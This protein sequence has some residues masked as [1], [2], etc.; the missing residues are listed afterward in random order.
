MD[1]VPDQISQESDKQTMQGL[2]VLKEINRI[3]RS[4]LREITT[5]TDTQLKPYIQGWLQDL[6]EQNEMLVSVVAE[7]E[8]EAAMRVSMLEEKMR[9]STL[10][11]DNIMQKYKDNVPINFVREMCQ[12][13]MFLQNDVYNLLEFIKRIR[14]CNNWSTVGLK[15]CTVDPNVLQPSELDKIHAV[16]AELTTKL[17]QTADQTQYIQNESLMQD[18]NFQLS[19]KEEEINSVKKSMLKA[20]DSLLVKVSEKYEQNLALRKTVRTLE[21]ELREMSEEIQNRDSLIAELQVQRTENVED[22]KQLENA[23]LQL[24][25]KDGIIKQLHDELTKKELDYKRKCEEMQKSMTTLQKECDLAKLEWQ[26]RISASEDQ[27]ALLRK[28]NVRVVRMLLVNL[29]PILFQEKLKANQK[30]LDKLRHTVQQT[31]EQEKHSREVSNLKKTILELE[32]KL[33]GK[34]FQ[35]IDSSSLEQANFTISQQYLTISNLRD[36]L[37]ECKSQLDELKR[38]SVNNDHAQLEQKCVIYLKKIQQLNS[39]VDYLQDAN[40]NLEINMFEFVQD[41]AILEMQLFKYQLRLKISNSDFTK[42]I[43][44]STSHVVASAAHSSPSQIIKESSSSNNDEKVVESKK[45]FENGLH[46]GE[47]DIANLSN[48]FAQLWKKSYVIPKELDGNNLKLPMIEEVNVLRNELVG[49]FHRCSLL[50][51]KNEARNLELMNVIHGEQRNEVYEHTLSELQSLRDEITQLE[52]K[53]EEHLKHID[54]LQCSYTHLQHDYQKAVKL[55]DILQ[56]KIVDYKNNTEN[57]SGESR[58]VIDNVRRWLEHQA[59]INQQITQKFNDDQLLIHSLKEKVVEL[60]GLQCT[61]KSSEREQECPVS[62]ASDTDQNE[63]W[64]LIRVWLEKVNR[65]TRKL[66]ASNAY[67]EHK[68]A[69]EDEDFYDTS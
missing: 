56:N 65:F 34:Q 4:K 41:I 3:F 31:E 47:K 5:T 19:L 57:I 60:Q 9:G 66:Q 69:K 26:A 54:N 53:N 23:M 24:E 40:L 35:H 63:D 14:Y 64:I 32:K 15:F 43:K 7:L 48:D 39:L 33:N 42:G 18:L 38:K 46:V 1:Q 6:M 62:Y 49:V 11:C 22:G 13:L 58:N 55:I 10:S 45:Q 37:T 50:L 21:C 17:C 44:Q 12:R 27:I 51:A 30:N 16:P 59:I 20:H 67:W 25:M 2:L 61:C 29:C 52:S 68:K 28:E 8:N 36:A